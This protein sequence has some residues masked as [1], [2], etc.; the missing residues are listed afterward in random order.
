[1]LLYMLIIFSVI[2]IFYIYRVLTFVR[3]FICGSLINF[4]IF[5]QLQK[6]WNQRPAKL[7]TS[8]VIFNTLWSKV[9]DKKKKNVIIGFTWVPVSSFL[10]GYLLCLVFQECRCVEDQVMSFAH[11]FQY[12]HTGKVNI[13]FMSPKLKQI[14][15]T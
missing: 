8:K 13:N 11:S 15:L 10:L 6:D 2:W 1:M 12:L 9:F 3:I 5:W 4:T 7:N 14:H